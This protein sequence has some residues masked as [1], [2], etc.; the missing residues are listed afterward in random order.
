MEIAKQT[1][2]SFPVWKV[3][4]DEQAAVTAFWKALSVTSQT[5]IKQIE[6]SSSNTP[7]IKVLQP[8][9]DVSALLGRLVPCMTH[10]IDELSG[11]TIE[12]LERISHLPASVRGVVG[13]R[14]IALLS[15]ASNKIEV[16]T[17]CLE[18][19]SWLLDVYAVE[20]MPIRR[21]RRVVQRR[22]ERVLIAECL[23][24]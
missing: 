4:T 21:L 3:S 17:V 22:E 16:S 8:L 20:K 18:I 1:G 9:T 13:E 14:I 24:E 19:G 12:F 2:R 15:E 7:I 5:I 6:A 10:D 23:F 11:S